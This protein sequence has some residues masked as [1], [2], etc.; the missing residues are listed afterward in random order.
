MLMNE[1]MRPHWLAAKDFNCVKLPEGLADVV[2]QGFVEDYGCMLLRSLIQ[3]V[4]SSHVPRAFHDLP[5]TL[6]DDV[7]DRTGYEAYCHDIE[8][9]S[10]LTQDKLS[11]SLEFTKQIMAVFRQQFPQEK[12]VAIISLESHILDEN[13]I[14]S[15]N[16]RFHVEREG[17]SWI[18]L[19]ENGF[20]QKCIQPVLVLESDDFL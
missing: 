4:S 10:F 16:V 8:I 12:L 9:S 3:P 13:P 14:P 17:E 19:D 5:I 20:L 1:L 6:R 11:Y 7:M 2:A 18:G 15:C